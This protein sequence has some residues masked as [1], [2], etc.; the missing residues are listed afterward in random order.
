[1]YGTSGKTIL[2]LILAV[3]AI[4]LGLYMTF[5]HSSDNDKQVE[6][7]SNPN[8]ISITNTE[9]EKESLNIYDYSDKELPMSDNVSED[10]IYSEGSSI[11][12]YFSNTAALDQGNMPLEVQKILSV[13]VQ[14]YL[15]INGYDDVTELYID[16]AS[17]V[18]TEQTI[19]FL[20]YMD[21]YVEQLQ[22]EYEFA[23][24]ELKFAVILPPEEREESKD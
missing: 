16:E 1:M 11:E 12:V 24:Q 7:E 9:Q 10:E 4:I 19:S 21:G 6:T 20:C 18:E 17:Y 23:D 14:K 5:F 15:Y 3:A 22:I 13:R 2:K 8:E